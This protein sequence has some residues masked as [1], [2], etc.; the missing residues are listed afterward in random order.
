[1]DDDGNG[2]DDDDDDDAD[3]DDEDDDDNDAP[4]LQVYAKE[5]E[6]VCDEVVKCEKVVLH[7]LAFDLN[8]AHPHAA[9]HD[10]LT[11]IGGACVDICS[12]LHGA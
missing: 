8:V 5:L 10:H 2:D 3:D 6:A 1:M 12:R 11:K 4:P 7:A 9:L